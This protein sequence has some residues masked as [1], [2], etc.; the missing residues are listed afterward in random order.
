MT[1]KFNELEISDQIKQSIAEMGFVEPTPIQAEAI[2]YILEG[3]DIIGQAQTGTGKTAAFSIPLIEKLDLNN[4][5][6]QGIILCPTR[7]LAIQVTDEIRKLTKYVEG[8]KVVPIYG[9]QSYNIQLKALKRKPQIVVGT[10]GRVIDHINRKT[11]KL[12]NIKMLILDEADEMLKMGFR[13]DLEYI[14]QKTPTERQT[15]LFSATMPKAIQD[16]ANKYQKKPKL[17]QIE[18]K[19]LTVDNIKQEY[20]E[21]NNNQ[22]FDLLVRLLDHNHY[23]SAIVFCN[24]KREV[25]ELVVRLQEHNYMTEALHGD[26]K[27]QQRD[28]V[29]NSFRNK[30]IKIL[31]ATDVAARGID[32]NNVEAVFNYDIP[33]DDEAYVHRIGRTGRA[34]Q[35]GASYTFINP[36]QFHRLKSIERYIKHKID[37][38]SIPTV[39]DIQDSKLRDLYLEMKNIIDKN[40]LTTPNKVI[41]QLEDEGYTTA[42]ITNSLIQL[43]MGEITKEYNE[44]HEP[45]AKKSKKAKGNKKNSVTLHLNIGK[46]QRISPR[47][48]VSLLIKDTK[49][50]KRAI[51]DIDLFKKYSHVEVSK[52]DAAEVLKRANKRKFKG[53]TIVVQE[54]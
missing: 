3:N 48:I 17:I 21:L 5:S 49:L 7:E 41:E 14:L 4:R 36:K 11:V 42:Q 33:L 12:E 27:Q 28:R 10:P 43:I 45:A 35:S 20:F 37:K 32:V 22:K 51:G 54:L 44:I 26:L 47:D 50:N 23:Q 16:I 8:V 39:K 15:T 2:P 13:E 25:D 24:T 1:K 52:R 6:I 9:G 29:M 38:G 40:N 46:K 30:N 31:V 34:G 53:K 19:S 18:R